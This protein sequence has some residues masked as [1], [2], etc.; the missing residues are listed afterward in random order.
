MQREYVILFTNPEYPGRTQRITRQASGI[1]A[2]KKFVP[3]GCDVI[4]V[5]P[6]YE[7]NAETGVEEDVTAEE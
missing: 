5:S 1:R 6:V 2:A 3:K 4:S 7:K